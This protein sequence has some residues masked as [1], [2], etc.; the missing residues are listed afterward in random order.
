[1]P[2]V[3]EV[4]SGHLEA[5]LG[6]SN[7]APKKIGYFDEKITV[8]VMLDDNGDGSGAAMELSMRYD[9][10]YSVKCKLNEV[11]SE[12]APRYWRWQ[13]QI[14]P[15]RASHRLIFRA[16][17]RPTELAKR[18]VDM[19]KF[20]QV[21]LIDFSGVTLCEEGEESLQNDNIP[22]TKF[23]CEYSLEI[24]SLF[25][26]SMRTV[27]INSAK[28]IAC[29]ELS[30][31][32]SVNFGDIDVIVDDVKFDCDS[33]FFSS[34]TDIHFPLQLK[35]GVNLALAYQVAT[36]DSHTQKPISCII[37]SRVNS[38]IHIETSWI[39]NIDLSN[40]KTN[41]NSLNSLHSSSTSLL[42]GLKRFPND[43]LDLPKFKTSKS[44]PSLRTVKQRSSSHNSTGSTSERPPTPRHSSLKP[45]TGSTLSL[46]SG[47]LTKPIIHKKGLKIKV[48]GPTNVEVGVSFRWNL[49]LL[50]QS[51]EKMELIIY[52]QS[53]INKEYEKSFPPI[54]IQSSLTYDPVPLFS[55][56]QLVRNFYQKFNK[57]GIVSLSNH[58][59]V[60]LE[61]GSILQ[62]ELILVAFE[63]GLFNLYDLRIVDVA[64]M[65]VFECGKLLD[66]LVE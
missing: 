9:N 52:V 47:S 35:P 10:G 18:H 54:P 34:I 2:L 43:R 60:S 3:V 56:Q 65:S 63:R 13:G 21:G 22:L 37:S 24:V 51:T 1:M 66:V 39:T 15:K 49:E 32:K 33:W 23:E 44:A 17:Y 45:K 27:V 57:S 12:S 16:R 53:S 59:R 26:M 58:L 36:T 55:N 8:F 61:P 41:N 64:C 20:Q 7:A 42:Q 6:R 25:K 46:S 50:N 40:S 31:S 29:L 4:V 28:S 38:S 30:A 48:S 62:T 19:E 5:P 11:I 14:N